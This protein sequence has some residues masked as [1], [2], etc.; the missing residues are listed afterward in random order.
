MRFSP[1]HG[2][3]KQ[4]TTVSY[5]LSL[6]QKIYMEI[7]ELLHGLKLKTFYKQLT[8]RSVHKVITIS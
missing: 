7:P 1:R 3:V 4:N 8:K 5:E 2:A 6:V